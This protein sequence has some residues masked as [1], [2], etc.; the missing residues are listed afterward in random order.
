MSNPRSMACR[1]AARG[2]AL[3]FLG[4]VALPSHA[5]TDFFHFS[6]SDFYPLYGS[7]ASPVDT[8]TM[9][10]LYDLPPA[11]NSYGDI[12][13]MTVVLNGVSYAVAN[14][15]VEETP[16]PFFGLPIYSFT[17]SI[18]D[19]DP[20]DGTL[21]FLVNL[22]DLPQR[23]Y[24]GVAANY[25][26]SGDAT[27]EWQQITHRYLNVRVP[28]GQAAAVPEPASDAMLAVGL[29]ALGAAIRRRRKR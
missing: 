7:S 22:Q 9:N 18:A 25:T 17:G 12:E 24:H 5:E 11:E 13:R 14:A 27:T 20:S 6:V 10:V 3:A 1:W 2:A 23:G 15:Q 21:N 4:A 19:F 26:M 8:M 29:V 28:D 16:D